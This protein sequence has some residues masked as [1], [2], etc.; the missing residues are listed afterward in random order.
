MIIAHQILLVGNHDVILTTHRKGRTQA[1]CRPQKHPD[2]PRSHHTLC[3]RSHWH[4]LPLYPLLAHPWWSNNQ[5]RCSPSGRMLCYH[6]PAASSY[7][8][9]IWLWE[10]VTSITL[11]LPINTHQRYSVQ[12][13]DRTDVML[14]KNTWPKIIIPLLLH[15]HCLKITWVNIHIFINTLNR[16]MN[17]TLIKSLENT[18]YPSNNYTRSIE[19]NLPSHLT[20]ASSEWS[21]LCWLIGLVLH[22]S[23]DDSVPLHTTLSKKIAPF[24]PPKYAP[25]TAIEPTGRNQDQTK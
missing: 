8:Q 15:L 2:Y 1:V 20:P 9:C 11:K 21:Q 17:H 6:Q 18:N 5:G 4:T 13:L 7:P 12:N 19:V 16:S 3:R 25:W 22:S 10:D 24:P 23:R 14:K